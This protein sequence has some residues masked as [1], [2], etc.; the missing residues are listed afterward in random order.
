M[1]AT[2]L[3]PTRGAPAEQLLELLGLT[4]RELLHR[5]ELVP[6]HWVDDG[7]E[8][9]RSGRLVGWYVPPARALAFYSRR[10]HRAYGHV[11]VA[12]PTDRRA[13]A[14]TLLSSLADQLPPEILRLDAGVTGLEEAEEEAFGRAMMS[15][16]GSE[17]VRRFAMSVGVADA[18][19]PPNV[20]LPAAGLTPVSPASVAI[21]LL[22]QLDARGFRGSVDA[23]LLA[24]TPAENARLL[25][26]LIGGTYGRF[27]AEASRVLVT[28]EGTPIAAILC[29]EQSSQT[30]IVLDAVVDPAWRRRGLGLYL[31]RWSLRALRALGYGSA[32]LWVT[33]ANAPA[34]ALYDQLG[35]R[36]WT[37]SIIYRWRREAPVT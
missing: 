11:H 2:A 21:E 27:L 4:R 3:V 9:L 20:D 13:W 15:R 32:Q 16:P 6:P 8:D 36:P 29:A 22:Q 10:A 33:E 34:R 17:L 19:A 25:A 31:F 23:S 14:V 26:E 37:R 12:D 7:V 18:P 24:D 1:D 30:A 28:G 5:G 35:F